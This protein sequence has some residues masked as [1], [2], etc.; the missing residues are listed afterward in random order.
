MFDIQTEA[1]NGI[2]VVRLVGQLN[3]AE[4]DRVEKTVGELCLGPTARV[5][6][7]LSEL[8]SIDSCG[9]SALIQL[10][11]R[12]RVGG[13][14]VIL[15][16]PGPFVSGILSVTRLDR[17]FDICSTKAEARRQLLEG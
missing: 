14:R 3:A 16:A 15:V 12:A 5:A 8:K 17:W 6:I 1:E 11:T 2:H 7:D 4:A 10:V 9:L 13:G